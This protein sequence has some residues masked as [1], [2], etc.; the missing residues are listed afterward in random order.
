MLPLDL[1]TKIQVCL[2]GNV[3]GNTHTDRHTEDVKTITPITSEMWGVK[4]EK[5]APYCRNLLQNVIGTL[6]FSNVPNIYVS[7]YVLSTG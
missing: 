1:Y 5:Q 7:S 2:S 6:P 4:G 3:S